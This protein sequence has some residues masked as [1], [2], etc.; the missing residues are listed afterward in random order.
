MR[1]GLI[2]W[3]RAKRDATPGS[4]RGVDRMDRADYPRTIVLA[5]NRDW[6]IPQG[7]ACTAAATPFQARSS[8]LAARSG[9]VLSRVFP[10]LD[11][12]VRPSERICRSFRGWSSTRGSPASPRPRCRLHG[13]YLDSKSMYL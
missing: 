6:K 1:D 10:T 9:A 4:L 11:S 12:A 2:S 5:S 13:K 7:H 8:G 3:L